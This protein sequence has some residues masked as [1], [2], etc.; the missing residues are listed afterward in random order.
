MK[1]G[2]TFKWLAARD[3]ALAAPIR[4]GRWMKQNGYALPRSGLL[5]KLKA[6]AVEFGCEDDHPGYV[7]AG[8]GETLGEA[9]RDRIGPK[10]HNG[11]SAASVFHSS[12]RCG[13]RHDDV[14]LRRNEFARQSW[15]LVRG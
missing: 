13:N 14:R 11:H 7:P 15:E 5:K 8:A 12:E 3:F 1:V 6:L 2:S 4:L 10:R 9:L